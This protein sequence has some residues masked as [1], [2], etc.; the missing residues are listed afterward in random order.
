MPEMPEPMHDEA[1]YLTSNGQGLSLITEP[2]LLRLAE[3]W[4]SK[5][6]GR[7]MPARGDIDPLDI[8]W[9]LPN[10]YLVDYDRASGTYR[11]RLAGS[12]IEAVY[13]HALGGRGMRGATLRDFLDSDKAD[14]VEN[15][16]NNL[17]S[18]GDIIYMRGLIYHAAD[19][20]LTGERLLLPLA[21]HGESLPTGL[22]GITIS[23]W[24]PDPGQFSADRLQI[25]A[26]PLSEVD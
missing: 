4:L 3:Y 12:D 10:I 11:Y 16:W 1:N 9:A 26:I 19:R 20:I 21:E 7:L 15:R 18:R 17:V 5:R 22:L 14:L 24:Q 23:E 8:A 25:F 2:R 13:R 6:A